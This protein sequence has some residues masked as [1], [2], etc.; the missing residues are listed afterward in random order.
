MKR[1]LIESTK[2]RILNESRLLACPSCLNYAKIV[3]V[4]DMPE[5]FECP[6]C[7][8]TL[9]VSADTPDSIEK[10]RKKQD[11][12]VSES[13][14]RVVDGLKASSLL[15]KKNG[16]IVGIHLGWKKDEHCRR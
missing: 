10:I 5:D 16:K 7:K 11:V 3:R 6:K 12:L 15:I 4:K 14:K 2:V 8:G 1:I 9:G 13:D